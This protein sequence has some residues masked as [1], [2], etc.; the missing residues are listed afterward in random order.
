MDKEMTD[1]KDK[2]RAMAGGRKMLFIFHN[3]DVKDH[4][5]MFL[6]FDGV[7]KFTSEW[8]FRFDSVKGLPPGVDFFGA[9][10]MTLAPNYDVLA[11][12]APENIRNF[13]RYADYLGIKR[14]AMDFLSKE[15]LL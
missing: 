14:Q 2:F 12:Y 9:D 7:D 6:D 15:G 8:M 1:I 13:L 11:G 5:F 3:L 10:H 4:K